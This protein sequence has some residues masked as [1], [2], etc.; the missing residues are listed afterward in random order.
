MEC[1]DLGK[2]K[3]LIEKYALALRSD[4][5]LGF[6]LSICRENEDLYEHSCGPVSRFSILPI[7][8]LTKHLTA[9]TAFRKEILSKS[10]GYYFD[11][12]PKFRDISIKD[13]AN[14]TSGIPEFLYLPTDEQINSWSIDQTIEFIF[15]L[16]PK[17]RGHF[18]YTNSNYVLLSKTLELECGVRYDHCIKQTL[19]NQLEMPFTYSYDEILE[20]RAV[21]GP[22]FLKG[23]SKWSA[24]EVNRGNRGWGDS[25]F[26]SSIDDLNRWVTSRC[27]IE[28]TSQLISLQSNRPYLNGLFLNSEKS[29]VFHSGSTPGSESFLASFANEK[30]SVTYLSNH[31][32]EQSQELI[33]SLM[34]VIGAR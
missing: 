30:V 24:A 25:S 7:A 21:L 29:L 15:S 32:S 19:F 16:K 34:E 5:Q 2:L 8:S 27:F 18:H 33:P 26:Y 6:C 11:C 1:F 20:R 23:R 12:P 31:T 17:E 3:K 14:H 4:S 28:H 10:L 22:L 9:I 13:L